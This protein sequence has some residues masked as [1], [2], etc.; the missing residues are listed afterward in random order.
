MNRTS[1]VIVA[2]VFG[3]VAF[4]VIAGIAGAGRQS[5]G[6]VSAGGPSATTATVTA[7]VAAPALTPATV[8]VTAEANPASADPA[9]PKANGKYLVGSQVAPGTWQCA[10]P[11]DSVHWRVDD[12]A[13]ELMDI[14]LDSIAILNPGGYT[15]KLAHCDSAWVK[16]G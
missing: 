8:T 2:G 4:F 6:T 16:V 14:G 1:K 9:A 15:I 10:E 3:L 13:G 11:T 5:G 7:T 12:Q